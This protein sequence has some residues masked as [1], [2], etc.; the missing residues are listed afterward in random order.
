M[1]QQQQNRRLRTDSM[2]KYM[3]AIRGRIQDSG[4]GVH[5]DSLC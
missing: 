2:A 1:N 3:F 5:G 4:K